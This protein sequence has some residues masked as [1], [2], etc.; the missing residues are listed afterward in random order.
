MALWIKASKQRRLYP[1]ANAR[2]TNGIGQSLDVACQ[3]F[4]ERGIVLTIKR[5]REIGINGNAVKLY[6]RVALLILKAT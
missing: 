2:T 3:D 4:A 1:F 5:C 6:G